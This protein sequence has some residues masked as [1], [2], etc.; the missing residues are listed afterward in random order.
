MPRGDQTG[1]QGMGPRTGRAAG[2]CGGY[3]V[4]GYDN[5][6]PGRGYGRGMAWCRGGRGRRGQQGAGRGWGYDWQAQPAPVFTPAA[7]PPTPVE[8]RTFLEQEITGLK[9]QLAYLDERLKSL[10]QTKEE[11]KQ[12]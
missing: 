4:P 3:D 11:K 6:V 9:A 5:P 8:E 2:Y 1:P 7:P 10:G 12:E